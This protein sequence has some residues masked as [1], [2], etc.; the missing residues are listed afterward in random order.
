[1]LWSNLKAHKCPKCGADLT[2]EG[3]L[4][5]KYTCENNKCDFSIGAARYNQIVV[6]EKRKETSDVDPDERLS[7]LN[8]L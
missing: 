1:M 7:E 3:M 4:A 2:S 8:N 6:K 5:E